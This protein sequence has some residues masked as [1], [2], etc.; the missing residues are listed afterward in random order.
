MKSLLSV[1]NLSIAFSGNAPVVEDVSFSV[2][3]GETLALVG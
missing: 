3:E 2:D 1:N